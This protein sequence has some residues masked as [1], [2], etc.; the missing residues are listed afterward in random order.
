MSSQ[1]KLLSSCCLLLQNRTSRFIGFFFLF[2]LVLIIV[3]H[4][5]D[6]SKGLEKVLTFLSHCLCLNQYTYVCLYL[7]YSLLV[8][9]FYSFQFHLQV[10]VRNVPPDPDESVS[11]HV[12]H[13]FCVNHPDHYLT[14][15]VSI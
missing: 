7:N 13:F 15:Q 6:C 5:V 9:L 14:H 12:E 8:D 10:L 3:K 1:V 11:D 4:K 2:L